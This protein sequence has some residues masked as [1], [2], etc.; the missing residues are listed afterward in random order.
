MFVSAVHGH[1]CAW[2]FELMHASQ[3]R[4]SIGP[5]SVGSK[6]GRIEQPA[7]VNEPLD[8]PLPELLDEMPPE[9]LPE[10]PLLPDEGMMPE[11]L[12]PELEEDCESSS[13]PPSPASPFVSPLHAGAMQN[14]ATMRVTAVERVHCT[15]PS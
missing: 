11:L 3:E 8:D 1:S 15:R 9:L 10:L 13:G 2:Q 7:S 12:P 5:A 14:A 6:I 4:F